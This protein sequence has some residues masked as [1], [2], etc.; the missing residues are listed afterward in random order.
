MIFFEVDHGLE[1]D[2]LAFAFR[3]ANL[4]FKDVFYHILCLEILVCLLQTTSYSFR[5]QMSNYAT[6]KV[7]R[8]I[9]WTDF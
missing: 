6:S 2:A 7:T 9:G 1:M 4:S 3:I 5:S 8:G